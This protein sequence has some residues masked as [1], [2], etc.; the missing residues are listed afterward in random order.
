VPLSY[1]SGAWEDVD[2]SQFSYVGLD[3]Y[4]DATYTRQSFSKLLRHAK[5]FGKLVVATEFGCCTF[6]GARDKGALDWTIADRKQDRIK[7]PVQRDEKEQADE[8]LEVLRIFDSEGLAGAFAFTFV[9]P[10]YPHRSDSERDLDM[11]SYA[12]VKT[13]EGDPANNGY[14]GLPWEPKH[15]FYE[16]ARQY[17]QIL[18]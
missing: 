14:L 4:R 11:A 2:W 3:A 17:S 6:R 15:T 9:A 8:L 16:L 7:V 13:L 1:A 10:A 5:Q 18:P 12:I